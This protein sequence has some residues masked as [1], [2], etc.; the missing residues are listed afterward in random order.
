MSDNTSNPENIT[1]S[2][3][4]SR[5]NIPNSEESS[6]NIS[7]NKEKQNPAETVSES[8][9][10]EK[11]AEAPKEIPKLPLPYRPGSE[12]SNYQISLI[13]QNL[14]KVNVTTKK[15]VRINSTVTERKTS[16]ETQNNEIYLFPKFDNSV[17]EVSVMI[18]IDADE[19]K[20]EQLRTQTEADNTINQ[21]IHETVKE[22]ETETS[23]SAEKLSGS[24]Y[25]INLINENLLKLKIETKKG[26]RIDS[27]SRDKLTSSETQS[28]KIYLHPL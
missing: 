17:Q 4:E 13:N 3:G 12:S 25:Q 21:D 22:T 15:G 19:K 6:H 9:K 14:L 16:S 11:E 8:G 28:N 18:S 26:V 1:P 20:E 27:F 7:E 5:E 10:S 23:R 24:N 2:E